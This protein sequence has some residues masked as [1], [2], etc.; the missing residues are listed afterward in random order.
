[1]IGVLGP[2]G[3]GKSTLV[4]LLPRLQDPVAGQVRLDGH[5]MRDL[6]LESVRDNVAI[7]LQD[8]ILFATS[9]A[10]NIAYGRPG[11]TAEE[12][13]TAARDAGAH[14]FIMAL[15]QG[16]DTVVGER[17]GTLSGGQRQRIA[18]A[19]AMLRDAPI[20]VLDEATTGLDPKT[21]TGVRQALRELSAGRTTFIITRDAQDVA[22]CDLVVWV[23][24]GRIV[25][26][27]TPE[28]IRARHGGGDAD[29]P[30]RSGD[31]ARRWHRDPAPV[32]S[33]GQVGH[34]H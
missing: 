27:G 15:P 25:D 1:R 2:S 14:E 28:Q 17:G 29:E 19:R 6:T 18:V 8:S 24:R 23:D 13:E 9:V 33:A 21:A 11:A 30:D 22:D 20:V 32:G 31:R 34:G 3:G 10:E 26:R 16:Y 5:D 4:S 7:V 12:I